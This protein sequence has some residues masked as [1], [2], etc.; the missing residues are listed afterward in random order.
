MTDK[1]KETLSAFID[2]EASEIEVHRLLRQHPGDDSLKSSWISFLQ[3]RSVIQGEPCIPVDSHLE[4][5]DRISRAIEAETAWSLSADSVSPMRRFAKPIAGLAVAATVVMGVMIGVYLR[6]SPAAAGQMA[7]TTPGVGSG[8]IAAQ[9]VSTMQASPAVE[10]EGQQL[11]L[12]QLDEEQQHE[13]RT[14]LN[15]HD[16]M[17]RMNPNARMV[18]FE[19][20]T[21]TSNP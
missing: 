20:P 7:T 12:R 11:E 4:L 6:Q 1:L 8:V 16:Q 10:P 15:M 13:L 9:P 14:Y 19:N 18:I 5:H 21:P 2:G 17:A 3:V